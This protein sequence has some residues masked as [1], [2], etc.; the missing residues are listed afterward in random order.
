MR[1]QQACCYCGLNRNE[2][3]EGKEV[4]SKDWNVDHH[5]RTK[6]LTEDDVG[7]KF[8]KDSGPAVSLSHVIQ[9]LKSS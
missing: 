3:D 5:T 6:P 1:E 4:D 8:K 7:P 9:I 2:H